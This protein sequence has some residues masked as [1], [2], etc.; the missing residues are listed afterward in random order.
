MWQFAASSGLPHFYGKTGV[1]VVM[2]K[3]K[4]KNTT[5]GSLVELVGSPVALFWVGVFECVSAAV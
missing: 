1:Y 3:N 4:D 5:Q 2:Y